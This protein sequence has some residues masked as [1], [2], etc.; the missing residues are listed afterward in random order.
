[1]SSLFDFDIRPDRYAVMGNPIAHSKSPAIHAMFAKQTGQRIEYTTILVDV[2]GF[3]QAVGNFAAS[4]GKGLNVTVPFKQ[5]AWAL[6][7]SRSAR[8]ER[9]GAVNTIKIERGGMLYGDNTD[10]IGLVTDLTT[11]NG[12]A[13]ASRTVLVIGAGGA[14]RGVLEPLLN[15]QPSALVIANR[16]PDRAVELA[17]QF[18][19]LGSIVGCG[20]KE[21]ASQ[22]FDVVINATSASLHGEVPDISPDVLR[23]D[24]LCYDMM[25]GVGPTAFMRWCREHAAQRV[26]DGLGMLVEQAAESFLIGRGVR[27]QTT[28]IIAAMR[29][30]LAADA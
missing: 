11:N 21:L 8:A 22:R 7:D 12:C 27:P 26:V 24:T 14:A 1:M 4:G 16:T 15:Q 18:R 13:I 17:G 23:A 10:G 19:D 29:Q 25:Y 20:F 6:V 3:A 9:A 28:P 5:E 30:S 2:G